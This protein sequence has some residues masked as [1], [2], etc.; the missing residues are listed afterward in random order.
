MWRWETVKEREK[1]LAAFKVGLPLMRWAPHQT[2]W[3]SEHLGSWMKD[4]LF[5]GWKLGTTTGALQTYGSLSCA[6]SLDRNTNSALYIST[7]SQ[8]SSYR[9]DITFSEDF[10][11]LS[12]AVFLLSAPLFSPPTFLSTSPFLSHLSASYAA[13][14]FTTFIENH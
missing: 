14:G 11:R 12:W 7:Y 6:F 9:A 5:Q 10:Q 3:R 1:K 4:G 8:V 2:E 13:V